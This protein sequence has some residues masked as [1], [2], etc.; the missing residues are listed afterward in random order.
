MAEKE[1]MK[2]EEQNEPMKGEEEP[3]TGPP[4]PRK[5]GAAR[6]VEVIKYH[7][8]FFKKITRISYQF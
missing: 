2:G 6:N 7:K 1:P 3:K 4:P 8:L 5:G